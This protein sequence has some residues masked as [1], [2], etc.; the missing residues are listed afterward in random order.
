MWARKGPESQKRHHGGAEGRSRTTSELASWTWQNHSC[1]GG[2][3]AQPWDPSRTAAPP[4]PLTQGTGNF[5][6]NTWACDQGGKQPWGKETGCS[7][8]P[9]PKKTQETIWRDP[10]PN[11]A[12]EASQDSPPLRLLE[13][14]ATTGSPG[15]GGDGVG[16]A[17]RHSVAE[18]MDQLIHSTPQA[19]LR[20]TQGQATG[21][22]SVPPH[23]WG[24]RTSSSTRPQ[25]GPQRGAPEDLG[26]PCTHRRMRAA[27]GR[28]LL[29]A[30]QARTQTPALPYLPFLDHLIQY[31]RG[32]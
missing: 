8:I 10:Q 17:C 4:V 18:L 14:Q 31:Q 29:S 11:G 32:N 19:E 21:C 16:A 24:L 5:P 28:P 9:E 7:Y 13:T 23:I 2:D 3:R 12:L 25:S 27:T 15:L 30:P 6:M 20:R 22:V 26:K 1:A